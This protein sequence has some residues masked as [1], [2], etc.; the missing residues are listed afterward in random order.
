MNKILVSLLMIGLV[1]GIAGAGTWAYFSDTESVDGNTFTAGTLDL[2]ISDLNDD[3]TS[4]L[5]FEIVNVKPG[6]SGS[7]KAKLKNEGNVA[8]TVYVKI[9]NIVN[10]ENGLKAPELAL[11]P[12]DTDA[13]GELGANLIV[14]IKVDG[15]APLYSGPV[16]S[17]GGAYKVD[18]VLNGGA[19]KDL[20]IDWSVPTSVGN[21]IQSDK[22]KFD[23]N[24]AL[25]QVGGPAP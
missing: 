4:K 25:V 7:E 19:S 15:G 9:S 13:T 22:L 12:P 20:I 16:N 6:D 1:I 21:I 2:K 23:V 5:P 18:G 24:V 3:S 11:V 10:E 8:G 17:F 14:T